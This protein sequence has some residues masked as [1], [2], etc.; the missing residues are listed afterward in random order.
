MCD[1]ASLNKETQNLIETFKQNVHKKANSGKSLHRRGRKD[2][3]G[4]Q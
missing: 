2:C 3:A 4:D 1:A